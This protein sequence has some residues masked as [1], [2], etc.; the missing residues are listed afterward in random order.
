MFDVWKELEWK[1]E[2]KK[3]NVKAKKNKKF[4]SS[5]QKQLKTK[6]EN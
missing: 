5:S 1:L 6:D 3:R 2:T 4:V